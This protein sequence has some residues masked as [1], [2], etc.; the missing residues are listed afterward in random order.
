MY[1]LLRKLITHIIIMLE[2]PVFFT[3][4]YQVCFLYIFE[5]NT[6]ERAFSIKNNLLRVDY[7]HSCKCKSTNLL[8]RDLFYPL[9][10]KTTLFLIFSVF[11]H[12]ICILDIF[13]FLDFP[14]LHKNLTSGYELATRIQ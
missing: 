2:V 7:E 6:K 13:V 3:W 8:N 4:F 5:T 10:I 1:L 9:N 14:Q 12:T 11:L